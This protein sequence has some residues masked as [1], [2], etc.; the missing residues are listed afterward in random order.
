MLTHVYLVSSQATPNLTPALD[1]HT[2]PQRV[3][4]IVS[5]GMAQQADWL[6]AVLSPR[7]K[8][9]RWQVPDPFDVELLQLRFLELLEAH[10]DLIPAK[11]IVLNA[12]GGTKPMSIAAYEAFRAYDLPM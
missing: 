9:V 4:L 12:T 1:R 8:T 10:A 6:E 3:I 2:A 11:Q 5:P 7:L